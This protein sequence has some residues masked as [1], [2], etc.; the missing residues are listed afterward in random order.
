MNQETSNEGVWMLPKRPIDLPR[1]THLVTSQPLEERR[2]CRVVPAINPISGKPWDI[3][4]TDSLIGKIGKTRVISQ[5]YELAYNVPKALLTPVA[6][7]Q[8]IRH[9][10][11]NQGEGEDEWLCYCSL[12]PTSYDSAGKQQPAPVDCVFLVFVNADRQV[13]TFRWDRAETCP[14]SRLPMPKDHRARFTR[15]LL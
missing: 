15:Q 2:G 3:R 8:G 5:A 12:P 4:I 9:D 11:G 6:I 10:A 13:Y 7:F 1:T 14:H